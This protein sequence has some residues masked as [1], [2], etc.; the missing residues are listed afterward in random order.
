VE[1]DTEL[2]RRYWDRQPCNIRHSSKPVGTKEYFDEVEYKKYRVEPHIPVF[3][4]FD[5]WRGKRVLEVGCGI[6]TDAVRFA[7]AGAI[8]TGIDFSHTTADIAAT[9]LS[10]YNLPGKIYCL[11]AQD[12]I[13][14]N[15]LPLGAFHLIYAFGSLHHMANPKEAIFQLRPLIR[16][17]G[18]LRMMVYA[19]DSWKFKMINIGQD[20]FESQEGCPIVHTYTKGEVA[21]LL[22]PH[23]Q[24]VDLWQTHIFPYK[25]GKYKSHEYEKEPW[26]EAMP[27]DMFERLE[28][29]LGWHLLVRALPVL[30]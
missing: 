3:A 27:P 21:T 15:I 22:H 19:R 20:Q 23:F 4:D 8:Y 11:D 18:E 26:F 28:R 16:P 5:K 30:R 7:R 14:Y 1:N 2:S 6:G 25:V 12:L 24:L 9:R 17:E 10:V 29:V 13:H